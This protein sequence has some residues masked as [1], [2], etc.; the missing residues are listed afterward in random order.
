MGNFNYSVGELTS[1]IKK[2]ARMNLALLG[3]TESDQNTYIW[4]YMTL[5]MWKYVSLAFVVRTSDALVV[6]ADG[7]VT[8][9]RSAVN[10]EDLYEQLRILTPDEATGTELTKRT[11]FAAG[12]GWW[13]ESANSQIHIKGSGTYVMQYKAY[14]A[15]A[16]IADQILEWPATSYDL[17][18]FETIGKIKESKD[19]AAGATA[20]YAV[21]DK[22]IPILVKANADA[23][24][25]TG[26][27]P[28]SMNEV[29]F[30]RR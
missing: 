29:S 10:I 9:K 20:A 15:K 2:E 21:A 5:A 28:P 27:R 24:G 7:F 25:T 18:M 30:Y 22:L 23:Q 1:M 11:S 6:S 8:F 16:A 4:Y 19:D 14:P 26:G 13:R 3:N 17:L 12:R